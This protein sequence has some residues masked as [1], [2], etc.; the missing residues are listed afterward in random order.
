V[1]GSDPK[2]WSPNVTH[3][4]PVAA[5]A[6]KCDTCKSTAI[7]ISSFIKIHEEEIIDKCPDATCTLI[8]S[9]AIHAIEKLLDNPQTFCE[10]LK[11]CKHKWLFFP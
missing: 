4:V 9:D 3:T 10:E 5:S 11:V 8:A 6:D 7:H 1:I 2:T